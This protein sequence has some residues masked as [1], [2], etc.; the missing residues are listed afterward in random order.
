MG[1]YSSVNCEEIHGSKSEDGDGLG[2]SASVT[3][4]CA[5][6]DRFALA[7]DLIENNR[8]W[9]DR[10]QATARKVGI[11]PVSGDYTASGQSCEYIYADL[12]VQY[13][14]NADQDIIT[15]SIEPTAEFR[16]LDHRLFRWGSG[17]GALLNENQAPGQLIRGFSLTRGIKMTLVPVSILSKPGTVNSTAYTSALLGLTFAAE[18]LLFGVQPITRSIKLSGA[19]AFSVSLKFTYKDSGWNKF[20]NE[21]AGA[22]QNIYIAGSGTPY[23]PYTPSSFSEYLY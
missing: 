1:I 18:T 11:K 13:N 3:L 19:T 6:N 21:S 10:S 20:W 2:F 23:K 7:E 22:Y 15:E 4:R 9:P 16:T 8:W 12:T 14:T 17:S 5:W